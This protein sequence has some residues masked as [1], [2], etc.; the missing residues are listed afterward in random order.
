[1]HSHTYEQA[2]HKLL[3]QAKVFVTGMLLVSRNSRNKDGDARMGASSLPQQ[4]KRPTP[5]G[6]AQLSRP[7]SVTMRVEV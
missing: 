5:Y 2:A 6:D 4:R 7:A 3:S 1:M